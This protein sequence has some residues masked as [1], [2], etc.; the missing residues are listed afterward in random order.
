MEYP[1]RIS[2]ILREPALLPPGSRP[3]LPSEVGAV[4]AAPPGQ[5]RSTEPGVPSGD[6]RAKQLQPS[7]RRLEGHEDEAGGRQGRLRGCPEDE[8]QWEVLSE[9]G[10]LF[11]EEGEAATE[12]DRS[13]PERRT[14][15][16]TP[17]YFPT[18]DQLNVNAVAL[19]AAEARW[20]GMLEIAGVPRGVLAAPPGSAAVRTVD[21][22]AI[23]PPGARSPE[24]KE[25]GLGQ[26][27]GGGDG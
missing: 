6:L 9:D 24:A 14:S 17:C 25:I 23:S 19:A 16:D 27:E 26:G 4:V 13:F 12:N 22:N 8:S 5:A 20:R 7:R 15:A 2:R 11:A 1:P 10:D 21:V 3:V 18:Y